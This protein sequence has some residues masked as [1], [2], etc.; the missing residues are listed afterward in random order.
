M[1]SFDFTSIKI[2][3]GLWLYQ[4]MDEPSNVIPPNN[5]V[6][7]D[8]ITKRKIDFGTALKMAA[9]NYLD[10]RW[11]YVLLRVNFL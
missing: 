8:R 4:F 5:F 11:A 10:L 6:N 7:E 3:I 1:L 2:N 9:T